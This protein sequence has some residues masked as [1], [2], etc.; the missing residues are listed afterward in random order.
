MVPGMGPKI[1]TIHGANTLPHALTLSTLGLQFNLAI[2]LSNFVQST[3]SPCD[4][5]RC[6]LSKVLNNSLSVLQNC[7]ESSTMTIIRFAAI[8][9]DKL[10]RLAHSEDN[11]AETFIIDVDKMNSRLPWCHFCGILAS[12]E[13]SLISKTWGKL[14]AKLINQCLT[15]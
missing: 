4:C 15:M 9:H 2:K 13:R 3:K 14:R 10:R 6:V 11:S 5:Y 1:T 7:F 8:F 12:K